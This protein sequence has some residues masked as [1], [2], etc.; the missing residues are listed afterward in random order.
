MYLAEQ[1]LEI[2]RIM[3]DLEIDALLADLSY[4]N[5]PGNPIDPDPGDADTT[6]FNRSWTIQP[7]TPEVGVYTLAVH[8]VWAD[9]LGIN[10]TTTVQ[11]LKADF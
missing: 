6:Q 2:F 11:T 7:N 8:V 1:Q 9:S 4:P 10:R 5:D 3:T